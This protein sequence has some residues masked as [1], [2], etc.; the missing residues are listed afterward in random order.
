[1][2]ESEELLGPCHSSIR[3]VSLAPMTKTFATLIIIA[4]LS[5]STSVVGGDIP[6]A[7]AIRNL[8]EKACTDW[9]ADK[10][11]LPELGIGSV[12]SKPIEARGRRVGTRYRLALAEKARLELEVIAPGQMPRR[13]ISRLYD[14][15]GNPLILL[16]MD[17]VCRPQIARRIEYDDQ[18]QAVAIA[19]LDEQLT[20]SGEPD[21]INPPLEFYPRKTDPN[22]G[23]KPLRIGLVDSGVDYRIPAIN[24]RLAR[25]DHGALIGY[26]FWD[27]DRLPFDAN[28]VR[29]GFFV[30]RHGTRT[31][32]ILLREAPAIELVPY[33]YPR[34]D[35][36][37]MQALIEHA[38]AN[39]VRIVGLPLGSNRAEDWTVFTQTAEQ[40]PDIL[41]IAS[42]GN[43]GR[44]IDSTP[45]YPA[46]LPLENLMV[47]TS[48]DDYVRPAERTNWGRQSVDYMLPAEE[49][50]ALDFN[51]TATRVSGSSYA[52]SR[53]LALA[54]RLLDANRDWNAADLIA[55]FRRRYDNLA[56]RSGRWVSGGYI[57]DPLAGNPVHTE[58]LPPIRLDASPTG[59]RL[60]LDLLVL[61]PRWPYRRLQAH[62]REAFDILAQCDVV[63]GDV[64]VRAMGG[65]AYLRDLTT[66][67]AHT[68]MQAAQNGQLTVVFARD[69]RML[70]QFDGEAFGRG[71][72][73]MRPWMTHSVWLMLGVDDP[74]VA[75]AHELVHVLANSGEHVDWPDNLMQGRTTP[76]GVKLT[77][78]QCER[79][80]TN[81]LAENLL[82]L[83][84]N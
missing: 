23:I 70:A 72:T 58:A 10:D 81:G 32:S 60:S 30:Q 11:F 12:D 76:D 67:N 68:L 26:D 65:D 19:T 63:P 54:S 1:M 15:A 83:I 71:N 43:N 14:H 33:R 55:E 84:G 74:G 24:H 18:G 79:I 75:L 7:E 6:T 17:G 62:A 35:M 34:I 40:H 66:G 27:M 36:S 42:A 41:F 31:A 49:I 22:D 69:T 82:E 38:D 39:D 20:A 61:D 25:D 46:S 37:R 8:T 78:G 53:A 52:V 50:D 9:R 45:V 2:A 5:T 77:A 51:G 28:P 73:G 16:A 44:D 59:Y 47:V 4:A 3:C 29:D 48:A 80:Q 57:P 13:F 64:S 21:W 56:P